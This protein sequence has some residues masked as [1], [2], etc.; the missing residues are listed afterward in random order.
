MQFNTKLPQITVGE[1]SQGPKGRIKKNKKWPIIY[2]MELPQVMIP[3]EGLINPAEFVTELAEAKQMMLV[4]AKTRNC[5]AYWSKER[6]TW[7]LVSKDPFELQV[8]SYCG[9][10]SKL[11]KLRNR[12]CD[13]SNVYSSLC[14]KV[15]LDPTAW[16]TS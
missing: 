12:Q 8:E 7:L 5:T 14:G 9:H 13:Y 16:R 2:Y 6:K 10:Y 11:Q 3:K 15:S 1:E 4:A